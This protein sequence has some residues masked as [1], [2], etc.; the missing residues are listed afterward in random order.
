V[1]PSLASQISTLRSQLSGVDWRRILGHR[2]DGP[3]A[4]DDAGA[5]PEF[6]IPP[7]P[8]A[9]KMSGHLLTFSALEC[10]LKTGLPDGL[11]LRPKISIWVYFGGPWNGKCGY[12]LRQFIII[13]D[14]LV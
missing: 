12:I 13:Y 7:S 3:D 2:G 14:H 9:K 5:N 8:G 11:I 1:C 6:V 10:R 4:F